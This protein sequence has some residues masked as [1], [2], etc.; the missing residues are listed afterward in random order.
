MVAKTIDA[1]SAGVSPERRTALETREGKS[2]PLPQVQRIA[3]AM[4]SLPFGRGAR[5]AGSARRK[6][7]ARS[8]PVQRHHP[9]VSPRY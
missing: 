9:R 7:T 6:S 1:Y 4:G 5:S 3:F 2:E 8:I